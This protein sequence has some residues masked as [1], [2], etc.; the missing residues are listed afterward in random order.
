MMLE[1]MFFFGRKFAFKSKADLCDMK[2]NKDELEQRK[3]KDI[4]R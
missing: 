4:G 3:K 1:N 2:A